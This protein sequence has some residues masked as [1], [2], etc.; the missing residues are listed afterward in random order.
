MPKLEV[1]SDFNCTWCYLNKPS[2]K[3][4]QREYVVKI[5]YRAFP[6]LCDIPESGMPIEEIF[7]NNIPLMAHKMKELEDLASLLRLPLVKR[8]IISNSR[9]SQE[10]AKWAEESGKI[11]EYHN[12]IYKACFSE[13]RNIA[14]KTILSEIAEDCGLS[15]TEA[16]KIMENGIFSKA[17]EMDW[18]KSKELG[19]MAVPAYTMNGTKLVG[20]Q[21]YNKLEEL[22]FANNVKK[23]SKRLC[24]YYKQR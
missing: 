23:N 18:E 13:G 24:H 9:L 8:T 19:I 10:L 22:M 1:Y 20:S 5:R 7:G 17:V 3:R 2:I 21:P 12:T 15:K 4:L 14:D 16:L 11:E 6:L